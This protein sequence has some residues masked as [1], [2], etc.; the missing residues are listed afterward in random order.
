MSRVPV[1]LAPGVYRNGT[2]I[3][4]AGRYYAANLVRWIDKALAPIG[5]WRTRG[6][7]T[8]TGA[9]RA[10]L[11]WKDNASIT[12][13]GI[14][15][16]NHLYVSNRSGTLFDITP[17]GLTSGRADAVAAGGFGSGTFGTGTF[18]T[19]RLDSSLVLDATQCSLDTFGQNLLFISPDDNKLYQWTLNTANPAV[20]VSGAPTGSALVVTPEGFAVVLGTT[21]PRTFS[22]CDQRVITT[23]TAGPTNQAGNYTLQTPGRLM[24]GKG[25][26][27][28]TL[29]L[30]D[31]DAWTITYTPTNAV[32]STLQKGDACGA[33]SRQCAVSYDMQV[34]WMSPDL[35]FWRFNGYVTPIECDVLDYIRL[36][37]NMLQISKVFGRHISQYQ[38]IEWYYCSANSSEIDR[39]VVWHY[40]VGNEFWNIGRPARTCGS[41]KKAGFTYPLAVDSAGLVYD[42]EVGFNYDGAMPYARGGPIRLGNGDNVMS[43]MGLFPDD[44]T[45][46]DVSMTIF[47]KNN[48]DDAYT[49]L[50]PYTLT[51]QTDLRTCARQI[52]VQYNGVNLASWRVGSPALEVTEGGGR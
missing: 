25:F 5:G 22:W 38:E 3:L 9:A 2:D 52:E 1:A 21:D 30:T 40:E 18:G 7:G 4:S 19:P 15:T 20:V 39:C 28:G 37:I 44:L 36:D 35:N 46:G 8:V 34:A 29:I 12:W 48:P 6:A 16:H 47:A 45:V 33:I 31:Q 10:I 27:G 24:C 26:Q 42:H 23:W 51:S 41:D 13:I 11:P 17:A 32:F 50:G 43:I 49:Q 14:A